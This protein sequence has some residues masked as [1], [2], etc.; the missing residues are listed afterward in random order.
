MY[1]RARSQPAAS[2]CLH[3]AGVPVGTWAG[4]GGW[5]PRPAG[6][7]SVLHCFETR[8]VVT[9][10]SCPG[11]V[12]CV[13]VASLQ[14]NLAQLHRTECHRLVRPWGRNRVTCVYPLA[15]GHGS[16]EDP[17]R[18]DN[19]VSSGLSVRSRDRVTATQRYGD[20]GS[21]RCPIAGT[22]RGSPLTGPLGWA[23][24]EPLLSRPL[25]RRPLSLCENTSEISRSNCMSCEGLRGPKLCRRGRKPA[26]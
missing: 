24:R 23:G 4:K 13:T 15:P 18:C 6:H 21:G 25:P 10:K 5:A 14:L 8:C 12:V 19:P 9:R 3:S 1:K 11:L 26:G 20:G 7:P 17:D 16:G 22:E 2:G